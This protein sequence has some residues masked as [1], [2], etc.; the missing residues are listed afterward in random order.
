MSHSASKHVTIEHIA[1]EPMSGQQ[2]EEAI[3]ALA[4]LITAWQHVQ[5]DQAADSAP[6]LPLTGT[7][8]DTDHAA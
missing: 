7:A 2:R 8:S 1:T 6:P 5:R 4:T 3:I